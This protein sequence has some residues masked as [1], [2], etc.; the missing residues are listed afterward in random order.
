MSRGPFAHL[1][2]RVIFFTLP[3]LI[4]S[5]CCISDYVNNNAMLNIF[6][7][8]IEFSLVLFKTIKLNCQNPREASSR[9]RI[10]LFSIV[11]ACIC[12]FIYVCICV[13]PP[14]Q[15]KND[16]DLKFVTHSPIDLI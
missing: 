14:G 12:V 2:C 16:T 10:F 4:L 1:D 8:A 3:F 15:T 6:I 7:V 13:T 9:S 5:K 11:Y